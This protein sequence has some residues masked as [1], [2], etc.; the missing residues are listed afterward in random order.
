M[1]KIKRERKKLSSRTLFVFQNLR[2]GDTLCVFTGTG[3]DLDGIALVD[4]E[5]N[6][7]LIAVVDLGGFGHVGGSIA[8]DTGFC[9]GDDL[10]DEGRQ[11]DFNGFAIV[12]ND[13]AEALF[14]K[15]EFLVAEELFADGH[16]FVGVGVTE[17]VV[18]T[19]EVGVVHFPFF[20]VGFLNLVGGTVGFFPK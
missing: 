20:E 12:E 14:D 1:V 2:L 16:F 17:N 10:F 5:G 18:M 11:R 6:L 4:E 15:E 13:I 3:I 8:A 9:F 19:V 7:D